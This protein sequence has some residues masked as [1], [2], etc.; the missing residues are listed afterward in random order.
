MLIKINVY[1]S[2]EHS[3][4]LNTMQNEY[5][6]LN[7]T[8]E[9]INRVIQHIEKGQPFITVSFTEQT[10]IFES[11]DL[12]IKYV[13]LINPSVI[14]N[15]NIDIDFIET[16]FHDINESFALEMK[17]ILSKGTVLSPNTSNDLR[18]L[19]NLLSGCIS[20]HVP[21]FFDRWFKFKSEKLPTFVNYMAQARLSH[22]STD[23]NCVMEIKLTSV[24]TLIENYSLNKSFAYEIKL[25][26][27][28]IIRN[29]NSLASI[30]EN[31]LHNLNKN[32]KFN[33]FERVHLFGYGQ[34]AYL[35]TLVNEIVDAITKVKFN[36]KLSGPNIPEI[37]CPIAKKIHEELEQHPQLSVS[38]LEYINTLKFHLNIK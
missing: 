14:Q 11:A 17:P 23:T 38:V 15:K 31:S 24:H 35:K 10:M 27:E 8:D 28:T 5:N 33:V 12:N 36:F 26:I 34:Q 21:E 7:W 4:E 19:Y 3:L 9:Q 18:K 20:P 1:Y 13:G 6:P 22:G 25:N 37:K 2:N 29:D 30:I 16:R 32:N